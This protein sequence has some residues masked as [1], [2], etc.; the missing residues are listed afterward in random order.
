MQTTTLKLVVDEVT[1]AVPNTGYGLIGSTSAT[2]DKQMATSILA[3]IGVVLITTLIVAIIRYRNK[4]K[5]G[6]KAS[7]GTMIFRSL[8]AVAAIGGLGF[9]ANFLYNAMAANQAQVKFSTKGELTVEAELDEENAIIACGTDEIKIGQELANGYKLSMQASPLTLAEEGKASVVVESMGKE[10]MDNTW[11]YSIDDGK[12]ILPIS[13]TMKEVK[14]VKTATKKDDTTKIKFC[15]KL[16]SDIKAGTYTSTITYNV[17]AL[18]VENKFTLSFDSHAV[19]LCHGGACT[20]EM[21]VATNNLDSMVCTA[22]GSGNSCTIKIPTNV[23]TIT[24]YNFIGWTETNYSASDINTIDDARD[25]V[26]YEA[27]EDIDIDEN[28]KL[29]AVWWR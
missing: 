15:T 21:P 3:I 2:S 4:S 25:L 28:T 19:Y 1:V 16:T 17:E 7:K 24:G 11:G 13:S 5:F 20:T 9:G 29:Y 10:F 6:L 14:T 18:E 27:G 22:T 8:L 12:D 23:P 26:D